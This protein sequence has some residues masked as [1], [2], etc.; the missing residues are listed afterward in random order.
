MDL[1]IGKSYDEYL[2]DHFGSIAWTHA[3][4]DFRQLIAGMDAVHKHGIMHRD[5]KPANIMRNKDGHCIIVD[6][7]LSKNTRS[8]VGT[9]TASQAFNGTPI[10]SAPEV[11]AGSEHATSA[12]DVFSLGLI[13][14]EA[15]SGHL[16][17]SV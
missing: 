4:E 7:G 11:T 15:V 2:Q 8:S 14:Y 6:F 16:P 9:E 13:F 10:Y 17:F 1:V 3:S 5:L 12:S